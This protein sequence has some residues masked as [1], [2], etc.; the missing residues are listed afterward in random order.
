M[1]GALAALQR[2]FLA[3]LDGEGPAPWP[4]IEVYRATSRANLAGALAGAYPVA[5]RLVGDAF[6]F[7]AA[8]RYAVEHPSASGDLND[9]GAHFAGFLRGYEHAAGL[10]YLPGVARLEWACQESSR[11]AEAPRFDFAALARV[12]ATHFALLRFSTHPAVRL[13]RSRHPIASIW[14]A[15]QPERDG[16]P[17]RSEGA[18]F[19]LVDRDCDGPRVAEIDPGEWEFLAAL[20]RGETLGEAAAP[21]DE[22]SG[23]RVLGANL[24]RYVSEGVICGFAPISREA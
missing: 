8:R 24:P 19:V 14:R 2:S 5:R 13:V 16:V 6:F 3:A 17:D 10:A 20:A 12:P 9:Y 15:N 21:L 22:A 4:G 18:Q 11:A 7:E 1:T 23:A